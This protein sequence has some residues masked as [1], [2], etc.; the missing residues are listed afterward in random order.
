MTWKGLQASLSE[1]STPVAAPQSPPEGAGSERVGQQLDPS[2]RALLLDEDL[3]VRQGEE[4][5]LAD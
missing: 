1:P 5:Y 3:R 4:P 2:R